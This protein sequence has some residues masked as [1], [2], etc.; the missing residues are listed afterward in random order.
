MALNPIGLIVL[1]V[2]ALVAGFTALV[3]WI[4]DVVAAFDAMPQAIQN[5]LWPFELLIKGIKYIKDNIGAI[6][7]AAS[8]VGGWFSSDD[9]EAPQPDGMTGAAVV[10]PGARIAQSINET[11][12]TNTSEIVIK[13]DTGR[14]EKPRGG[15]PAGISMVQ[16]GGF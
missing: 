3:V 4:D 16:S 8:A 15:F 10:S 1:G 7:D 13:D 2:A 12:T 5:I 9:D 14:A 11:R 6:G